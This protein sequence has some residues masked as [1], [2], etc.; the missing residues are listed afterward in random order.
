[1][2]FFF[3]YSKTHENLWVREMK[4]LADWFVPGKYARP[5]PRAKGYLT[6]S[7]LKT[8]VKSNIYMLKG[9]SAECKW[10]LRWDKQKKCQ[11]T[12]FKEENKNNFLKN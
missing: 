5:A 12:A 9:Y 6:F 7:M 3:S 8:L 10:E 1:M 4:L 11:Y 2:S